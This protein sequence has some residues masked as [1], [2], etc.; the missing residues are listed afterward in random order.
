MSSN[1]SKQLL[2]SREEG[3]DCSECNWSG[4]AEVWYDLADLSFEWECPECHEITSG[5][6]DP[7]EQ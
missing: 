4:D 3:K 7:R 5:Y 1:T 2:G 6:H